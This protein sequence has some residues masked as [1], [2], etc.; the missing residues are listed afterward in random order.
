M[1]HIT[2]YQICINTFKTRRLNKPESTHSTKLDL[3]KSERKYE[4]IKKPTPTLI[5]LDPVQDLLFS[6]P[7]PYGIGTLDDKE[8]DKPQVVRKTGLRFEIEDSIDLSDANLLARYDGNP[9]E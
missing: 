6:H 7:D 1:N 4:V 5:D 9:K 3:P 2:V 8:A